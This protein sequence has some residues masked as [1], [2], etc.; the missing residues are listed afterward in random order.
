[1]A[2]WHS[3]NVLYVGPDAR[4]VWQF[5]ASSKSF[6]L[7]R[8][9]TAPHGQPLPDK[10]VTKDWTALWQ[11]KLN[12]AWLPSENVFL[13][14]AQFPRSNL[15]ETRAMV[16]LQLEKLSPIPVTQAVWTFHLLPHSDENLQTVVLVI[17]ARNVVE[18]FLGRLEGQNYLA[19]RLELPML[20]QLQATTISGDGAW[21]YPETRGGQDTA[22]VAWWYSGVLRN[23]DL[24]TLPLEGDRTAAVKDQLVQM[25]WAGEMEGW[26]T[27]PP[28]WHL[29]ADA[30]TASRWE[31]LVREKME[32][33][34]EVIEPLPP[35]ELAARTA[36][37]A[38]QSDAKT[39]LLPAEFATRYQQ[40]F[41]D[42]LWIR[43]LGAV[44][45]LYLIG[46]LIYFIAVQV[47][48]FQ[49]RGVENKVYGLANTYTNAI[50]AK[51]RLQVLKDRQE[52]KYA[53]LECWRTAAEL[54]PETLTLDS[55][56]FSD[57]RRLV[58][59]GVAA[60]DQARDVVD[61]NEAMRKAS[62]GGQQLFD[63]QKGTPPV[64]TG[65]PGGSVRWN[66]TLELKRTEIVK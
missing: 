50:Q 21:I 29:V 46:L 35:R 64:T 10:T 22:L 31:P 38:A 32:Q 39:N 36:K 5:D 41:V 43:G 60:A 59:S 13:R 18:E 16:E 47:L 23:L 57:G 52:L 58:L 33:P 65:M 63:P 14:V 42:R 62:V 17:V 34:V 27:A 40:Q 53:A 19:D 49:T 28:H 7:S 30:S 45:G 4:R 66:F 44:F 26:L 51:A 37:R 9:Q 2:R 25:A 15:D 56:A 55:M 61:F 12:V 24:I 48:L 1:M 54:M 8:E 3:C 20:D 6:P 11:R